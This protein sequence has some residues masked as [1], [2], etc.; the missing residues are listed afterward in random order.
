MAERSG[1]RGHWKITAGLRG[2][3]L[4][5]VLREGICK[6]EAI[7]QRLAEDWEE[8]VS[9]PS[10]QQVL[11]ENGLREPQGRGEESAVSQGEL[12]SPQPGRQRQLDYEGAAA[13]G[14]AGAAGRR[15]AE[16]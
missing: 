1:S 14:A 6:L 5:V 8:A 10:I 2:K 13:R 7:Q 12:F 9:L 4:Q 3:I 16:R 11:E 15:R